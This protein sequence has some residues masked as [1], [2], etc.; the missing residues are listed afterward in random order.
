MSTCNLINLRLQLKLAF[1]LL[2][3][4]IF[5]LKQRRFDNVKKIQAHLKLILNL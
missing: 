5:L 3:F 4:F 2:I 1:I